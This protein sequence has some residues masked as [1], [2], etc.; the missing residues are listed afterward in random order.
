M[1]N[2]KQRASIAQETLDILER[3]AYQHNGTQIEFSEALQEM[4]NGTL[5]YTPSDLEQLIN[6]SKQTS[7]ANTTIKVLNCTTFAAAKQ[8]VEEGHSNPLC[9]NFAS[10]KNPGGGFL[11][12]SQAQEEAL[13]RA[14][15][16]YQSLIG[17]MEYYETN[18]AYRSTLYTNHLIYSPGVPVFRD[19]NDQFLEQPYYVSI[20]T[21]P[22]VN[23]GALR[24]NSPD[25]MDQ[26]KPKMEERI[27]S[28][29]AVAKEHG[30][31]TLVL[32]A[33]GCGVFGNNPKDIASWF[34]EALYEDVRFK[35]AFDTVWFAVLDRTK[36][37]Y[38][39]NAFDEALP[40]DQ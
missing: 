39:F 21:S 30:H 27:R 14:S 4:C 10:A 31:R 40:K 29:L 35:N 23:T 1:T 19:D 24:R 20:I 37:N 17:K 25:Q 28:V 13:A 26:V 32:G 33:W 22:A 7:G 3:G 9:L 36:D 38:I 15:G 6:S 8:L 12:G 18:R 16:L 34:A 11:G 2:R 5:L